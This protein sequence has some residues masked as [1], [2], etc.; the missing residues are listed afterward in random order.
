MTLSINNEKVKELILENGKYHFHLDENYILKCYRNGEE[1]R[2]F[3]GDK[4][5]YALF[6]HAVELQDRID[7]FSANVRQIL[8]ESHLW[9]DED[10]E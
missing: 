6:L 3:I 5:I 9:L 2:D 4:A 8:K 1:W 10:L 7:T